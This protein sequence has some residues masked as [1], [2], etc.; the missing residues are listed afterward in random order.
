MLSIY[1]NLWYRYYN[2]EKYS[3][4][5]TE[6]SQFCKMNCWV[7]TLCHMGFQL[8][9]NNGDPTLLITRASFTYGALQLCWHWFI[10]S[11]WNFESEWQIWIFV[12]W[13]SFAFFSKI[14]TRSRD[15]HQMKWCAIPERL[16]IMCFYWNYSWRILRSLLCICFYVHFCWKTR[17]PDKLKSIL[18]LKPHQRTNES[19]DVILA[20]LRRNRTFEQ[21]DKEVKYQLAKVMGYQR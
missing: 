15:I 21:Y 6:Q 14:Y 17:G 11:W 20:L 16:D 3:T 12:L 9:V 18:S 19:L 4:S 7:K 2:C 5:R 8:K 10:A 13:L 1:R